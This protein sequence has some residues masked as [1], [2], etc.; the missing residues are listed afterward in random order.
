MHLTTVKIMPNNQLY[1]NYDDKFVLGKSNDNREIFDIFI[2]S[3]RKE[4]TI[5]SFIKQVGSYAFDSCRK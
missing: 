2:F 5:P 1:K 3:P 4:V